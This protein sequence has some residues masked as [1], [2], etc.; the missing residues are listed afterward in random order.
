MRKDIQCLRGV[1]IVS[2]F[3][4]HLFP[5]LFVNGFLGV[6]I[7]KRILP[8]YFLVILLT[9]IL[10]HCYLED[11]LWENN[12]RYALASLFLVTNQLVIDDQADYFRE[13]QAERTSLN[14]FVHLWSLSLEMQFYIFVPFIF[15]GLQILRKDVLKL[16][17]VILIT[18]I[19]FYFFA[20]INPQFSFNFM[21]LRLWQFSSGFIAL[22]CDRLKLF[23]KSEKSKKNEESKRFPIDKEDVVIVALS[24][25][26]ISLLPSK[27]EILISRPLVTLA[28]SFLIACK[29]KKNQFLESKTLCYIGDISYVM[30]LVHWPILSIFI[31]A[32]VKSHLFCIMLTLISSIVLHHIFEK[33]Y[34]KLNWKGIV[35][36]VLILILG[37]GYS[38]YSI[39]NDT[40]WKTTIPKEIESIVNSN[41]KFFDY[42]W[43]TESLRDKC[44]ENEIQPPHDKMYGYCK[45]PKG[46]GNFSIMMLGNSYVM[47]LGEHIRAHF[48]YN[49]SDYRYV[50]I[51]EGYGIY[52]DSP[53]SFAGL[54]VGKKQ[55]EIHKPDLLIIVARYT[56]AMKTEV[57][58]NDKYVIQ[59]NDVIEFYEKYGSV[60]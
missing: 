49:Y 30:Y 60:H 15:I 29:S 38:Q 31:A 6:D 22:F 18:V 12:D 20:L 33:Q 59:M 7:F 44:I 27:M 36:L 16:I 55:V 3:L 45:F 8:L 21:F 32:S 2:V 54:E 35:L 17:A 40:F 19:G 26:S 37:N 4:Y 25:I 1:A 9:V 57:E 43:K 11:F 10:V 52:A 14:V 23:K 39:R 58:Q 5:T 53:I 51:N 48:N 41:K 42:F 47:N 24:I 34:L 56:R 13:F 50:S 46:K 28:T